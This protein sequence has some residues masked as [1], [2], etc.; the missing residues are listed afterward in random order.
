MKSQKFPRILLDFLVHFVSRQ[1]EQYI[2]NI[3]GKC[4][5]IHF[6]PTQKTN[7]KMCL[8]VG[9]FAL[10]NR[11]KTSRPVVRTTGLNLEAFVHYSDY[12]ETSI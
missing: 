10:Q 9:I 5:F 1:N 8:V 7:Q 12:K 11:S 3:L 2:G 4:L 6:L